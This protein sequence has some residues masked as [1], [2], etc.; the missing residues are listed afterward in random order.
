MEAYHPYG[1]SKGRVVDANNIVKWAV[2][3]LVELFMFSQASHEL[4]LDGTARACVFYKTGRWESKKEKNRL[5]VQ[6]R[7]TKSECNY[8]ITIVL[9]RTSL[10]VLFCCNGV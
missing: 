8:A 1:V 6:I 3:G 10:R 9:K 5:T 2:D 7:M 4:R